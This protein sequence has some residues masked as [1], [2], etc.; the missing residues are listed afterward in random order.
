MKL[1]IGLTSVESVRALPSTAFCDDGDGSVDE[2]LRTFLLVDQTDARGA[3][4]ETREASEISKDP[5][6]GRLEA[7]ADR[8]RNVLVFTHQDP[9]CGIEQGHL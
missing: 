2:V 9:W 5:D 1:P 7:R 8:C 3:A 4:L 6:S